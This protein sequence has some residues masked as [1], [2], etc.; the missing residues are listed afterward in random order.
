[1]GSREF[2]YLSV[3]A[4][5]VESGGFRH[6]AKELNVGASSVSEAVQQ[7]EDILGVRLFERTTRKVSLTDAGRALY[8]DTMPALETLENALDLTRLKAQTISGNLS[9]S[10]SQGVCDLFLND[11][12][13][14][15]SKLYPDVIVHLITDGKK[16]DL[17]TSGIDVAVR[18]NRLLDPETYA[19]PIGPPLEMAVIA[20]PSYLQKRGIP[21]TPEALSDFDG[22]V[23]ALD[24]SENVP[25]VFGNPGETIVAKP[26]VLLRSN[27]LH[28]ILKFTLDGLGLSYMYRDLVRTRLAATEFTEVL[29]DFEKSKFQYSLN[30]LKR[31]N[32]KS[33]AQAFIEFVN[34]RK[35]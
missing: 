15:F 31:K 33:T 1:M 16:N 6:A 34:H 21:Q 5:V 32:L 2:R 8:A 20:S 35:L 10:A 11:I 28:S 7:L 19:V 3:F 14:Q 24:K 13:T 25:W 30:Y 12:I 22:I 27:N 4:Q 26:K 9:I 17:V 29:G 18:L 23:Y